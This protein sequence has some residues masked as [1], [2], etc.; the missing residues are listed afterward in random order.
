MSN[1]DMHGD[2]FGVEKRD[3]AKA[4]PISGHGDIPQIASEMPVASAKGLAIFPGFR[5]CRGQDVDDRRGQRWVEP[6]EWTAA[7]NIRALLVHVLIGRQCPHP[8][9]GREQ[10]GVRFPNASGVDC[11]T[12]EGDAG[13]GWPQRDRPSMRKGER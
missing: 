12:F 2:L 13:I 7:H 3:A 1:L 10:G 9:P 6:Y 5:G 4:K 11:A 8:A